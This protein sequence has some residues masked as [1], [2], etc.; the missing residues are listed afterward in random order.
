MT[1][2]SRAKD[3]MMKFPWP[4]SSVFAYYKRSK[5]GGVEGLGIRLALYPTTCFEI[6]H[7]LEDYHL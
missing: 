1:F 6:Y 4:F 7:T 5:T 2:D 3:H